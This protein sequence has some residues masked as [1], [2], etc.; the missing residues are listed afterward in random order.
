MDTES[1]LKRLEY[2]LFKT[3]FNDNCVSEPVSPE[4]LKSRDPIA[5]LGVCTN[6]L[7]MY[8]QAHLTA[9]QVG[10][11]IGN[12]HKERA[13]DAYGATL[14]LI[15]NKIREH[16]GTVAK[17]DAYRSI[18]A[19]GRPNRHD[20]EP[21]AKIVYAAIELGASVNVVMNRF[22]DPLKSLLP[23]DSVLVIEKN[24]L[25]SSAFKRFITVVNIS[26]TKFDFDAWE[27]KQSGKV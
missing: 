11:E 12:K 10:G 16:G 6:Y 23:A 17:T 14:D 15:F 9:V 2:H 27:A 25:D 24:F 21:A 5:F 1:E 19:G 22:N 26:G 4:E 20:T 18:F 7:M 13:A 8:Y 3:T